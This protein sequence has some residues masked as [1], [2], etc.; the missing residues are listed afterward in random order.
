[1]YGKSVLRM[2]E[3]PNQL[4]SQ[5]LQAEREGNKITLYQKLLEENGHKTNFTR[6]R[7]LLPAGFLVDFIGMRHLTKTQILTSYR[8][9]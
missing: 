9:A 4:L 3:T 7:V 8:E 6:Y 2:E 5:Q 1:M